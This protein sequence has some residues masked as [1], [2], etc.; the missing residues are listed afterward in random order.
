MQEKRIGE[1]EFHSLTEKQKKFVSAYIVSGNATEAAREAEYSYP[2]SSGFDTLRQKTVQ[3][4]IQYLLH[5]SPVTRLVIEKHISAFLTGVL[6]TNILDVIDIVGG[7]SI[8]IKE[9]LPRE[10]GYFVKSMSETAHGVRVEF[11]DKIKAA[12]IYAK[13]KG[14]IVD[15]AI[16]E[17][18]ESVEDYIERIGH[19]DSSDP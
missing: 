18:T 12:E 11:Y 4:A 13:L 3:A 14:L 6:K 5:E 16:E 1:Q 10:Y 2:R 9:N 8:V 19:D 7:R 17:K 15:K